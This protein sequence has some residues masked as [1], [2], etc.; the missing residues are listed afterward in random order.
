MVVDD[1]LGFVAH[2]LPQ[3][4]TSIPREHTLVDSA[5]LVEV[6][7]CWVLGEGGGNGHSGFSVHDQL[8]SDQS[9]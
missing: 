6:Q 1:R 4:P 7:R 3:V 5:T 8:A 2:M 9:L